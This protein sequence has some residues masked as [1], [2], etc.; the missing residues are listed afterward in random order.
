M[1]EAALV[2]EGRTFPIAKRSLLLTCEL[3]VESPELSGRPYAIQSRIAEPDLPVFLDAVH[4]A[5]PDINH[6]NA[7]DPDLLSQE[8]RP[9]SRGRQVAAFMA[10]HPSSDIILLKSA[11]VD[12]QRRLADQDH[13]ICLLIAGRGDGAETE[14]KSDHDGVS[15]GD[16]SV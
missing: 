5:T 15:G 13:H 2:Y 7:P 4:D 16:I 6:N 10:Q 1:M 12:V 3:F 8:F 11:L 9:T 14:P